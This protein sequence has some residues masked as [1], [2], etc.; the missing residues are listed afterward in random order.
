MGMQLVHRSA[1][2]QEFWSALPGRM[3]MKS[4]LYEWQRT[5]RDAIFQRTLCSQTILAL[6][7]SLSWEPL[8]FFSSK[9]Q[10]AP[11]SL[12][13]LSYRFSIRG[14][15]FWDMR[16][17]FSKFF[18]AGDEGGSRKV[19]RW[20]LARSWKVPNLR[21][22]NSPTVPT[23][24]LSWI[25]YGLAWHPMHAFFSSWVFCFLVKKMGWAQNDSNLLMPKVWSL[26]GSCERVAPLDD[27]FDGARVAVWQATR[28]TS[29]T[30]M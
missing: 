22:K 4:K 17:D 7:K 9:D 3:T 16:T 30:L 23:W 12:V 25:F 1:L 15:G 28:M 8:V 6:C 13:V 2:G 5:K 18:L 20:I 11:C 26:I 10:S 19:G 27:G 14:L 29:S 21:V 24:K